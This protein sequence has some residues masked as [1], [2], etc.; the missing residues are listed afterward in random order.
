[1]FGLLLDLVPGNEHHLRMAAA[2]V[3]AYAYFARGD[4][5]AQAQ[6]SRLIVDREGMH[7]NEDAK[8]LPKIAPATL[9]TPWPADRELSPHRLLE[10]YKLAHEAAW[11]RVG[12]AAPEALWQL[13]GDAKPPVASDIGLWLTK[14]LQVLDIHPPPGVKW[15][16]HSIRGGAASAALAIGVS[17]PAICRWG[18]WVALDSVMRYLDPLVPRSREALL[19]FA[20]LV[21]AAE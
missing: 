4:T 1:M 21:R 11:R 3:C 12:L 18:I 17:L 10:R 13:P 20:H 8:N 19:F 14:L 9:S 7:F 15:T 6:T 5:G 16:G 2:V